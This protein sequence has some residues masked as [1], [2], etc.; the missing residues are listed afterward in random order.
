MSAENPTSGGLAEALAPLRTRRFAVLWLATVCGNVAAFMRDLANAWMAS[1]LSASPAAVALV[2]AAATLPVFLLAIPAGALADTLDR[3]RLLLAVQGLLAAVAAALCVLAVSGLLGLQALLGLSLLGG[4]GAAL[5]APAWLAIVPEL[6][7][8]AQRRSALALNS[9]GVNIARALGPAAGGLLLAAAGAAAT[10]GLQLL[11]CLVPLAA[12]AWW[13]R[14]PAAADPL[15]EP[16]FGALRAGLRYSRA[17]RELHRVLWRAAAFFGCASAAWALLPWVARRLQPDAAGLYGALLG[18]V[19]VGA[20][21]G[22]L[23]MPRWRAGR[24]ADALL[25]GATLAVVAVL[26]GLA[27]LSSLPALVLLMALL[28]AA[29]ITALTT[30]TGVAQALFPAWVRGRGLAVYLTVFNGAMSFGSLAWGALAEALDVPQALL[31][32]AA[33]LALGALWALR[34]PLPAEREPRPGR[35][36]PAPGAR[37][38]LERGPVIVQVEYRVPAARRAQA[39]ALLCELAT[40]RR[41]DGA[42]DWW[43]AEDGERPGQL[44]EWFVVETW[45]EHLRQHRRGTA[46]DA[47][48]RERLQALLDGAPQVRH[49]LAVRHPEGGSAAPP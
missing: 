14:T 44:V 48:L 25:L 41:R 8:E 28:G 7:D 29:W 19:G 40:V 47:E 42:Q 45:A 6:V 31:V 33:G 30:L 18:V 26:P 12:L 22:A 10:Y 15:A 37:H 23:L 2:Q 3:R 39:L 1:E 49:L 24:D 4:V 46:A 17:S 32:A 35:P 43:L 11:I 27:L 5:M 36:W 9:L 34:Y 16:F 20:I 38:A 21:A 13:R